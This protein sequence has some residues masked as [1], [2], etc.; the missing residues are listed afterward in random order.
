MDVLVPYMVLTLLCQGENLV[1]S[2]FSDTILALPFYNK[3]EVE[4]WASHSAFSDKGGSALHFFCTIRLELSSYYFKVFCLA[5]LPLFWSFVWKK[6]TFLG[7]FLTVPTGISRLLGSSALSLGYIR[8]I[9]S[10][11][12]SLPCCFL[13]PKVPS[14]SAS[15]LGLFYI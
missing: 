4:V 5:R 10:P 2:F 7:N 13:G 12:N 8:Q 3:V 11:W 1:N 14:Q 6:Q 9:E 15:F